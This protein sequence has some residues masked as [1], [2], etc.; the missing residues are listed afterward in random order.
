[1]TIASKPCSDNPSH[2]ALITRIW[3]RAPLVASFLALSMSCLVNAST[4][5]GT[6]GNERLSDDVRLPPQGDNFVA[7][8]PAG[9]ELIALITIGEQEIVE[10]GQR[11]I[12]VT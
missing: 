8:G 5:V 6:V 1:M 3:K 11:D 7:Y 9:V 2:N 10:H 4:C 12:F